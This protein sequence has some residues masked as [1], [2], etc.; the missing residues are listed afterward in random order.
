MVEKMGPTHRELSPVS[1]CKVEVRNYVLVPNPSRWNQKGKRVVVQSPVLVPT[2]AQKIPVKRYCQGDD[3]NSICEL[4]T[5]DIEHDTSDIYK[6]ARV[7]QKTSWINA[8]GV[9]LRPGSG[10]EAGDRFWIYV[11]SDTNSHRT[12]VPVI[13]LR[14]HESGEIAID[15]VCWFPQVQG[16]NDE[17]WTLGGDIRNMKLCG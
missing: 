10:Y 5:E 14:T 8:H 1:D 2:G 17:L 3:L 7:S 13:N 16:H 6:E 12:S 11:A 9:A 15:H 4:G